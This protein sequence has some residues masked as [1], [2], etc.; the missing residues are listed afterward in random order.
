[1]QEKNKHI[2]DE[3]INKLPEHEVPA[4]LW[5]N[6]ETMILTLP[7]NN[8]PIHKPAEATWN[9]IESGIRQT[10]ISNKITYWSAA[11]LLFLLLI[12]GTSII[13]YNGINF[14]DP[15]VSKK[16][17]IDILTANKQENNKKEENN[18]K[19]KRTLTYVDNS[20]NPPDEAG[21]FGVASQEKQVEGE[22]IVK[23]SKDVTIIQF[24]N[25]I[26]QSPIN[27]SRSIDFVANQDK[28]AAS[29]HS[30]HSISPTQNDNKANKHDPFQEC[31]FQ[32][33]EQNFCIGPGFEYQY[34]LNSIVP[35][36]AKMKYWYTADLRVLF[37]RNHFFFETGIGVSFSKDKMNFSYNYLTNEIVNTYEYVDSVHYDPITGTTEY[38][39]TTVEVYDSIPYSKQSSSETSYNYLQIPLEIGYE[40]WDTKKF[41]LS[42]KTGITYFRELTSKA[43]QPNL[44]H[45]NSRIT[46]INSSKVS[47]NKE[48]LRISG[49]IG[50]NWHMNKR[51]NIIASPSLNYFLIN[52]YDKVEI[53][54]KPIGLGIRLGLY[55]KF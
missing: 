7:T 48:L 51:I 5:N 18:I 8:L 34:F 50:A 44:F 31:N 47:R 25:N 53:T 30:L 9:A 33:P 23:T 13:Y 12:G 11:I 52:I 35:E 20:N 32:R 46:S 4:E 41:S 6:I 24:R 1:L 37:Q 49:S 40:V 38:Y 45:E 43:I 29:E 28:K 39:T 22:S 3:G 21:I 10:N 36:N 26:I 2:L 16:S 14:N 15:H 54:Q 27:S 55:Y 17:N 19:E 42:I